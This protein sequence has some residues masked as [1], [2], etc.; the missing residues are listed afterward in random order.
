MTEH[1]HIG[2]ALDVVMAAEDIGTT[3]GHTHVA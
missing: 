2:G 3:A 1:A